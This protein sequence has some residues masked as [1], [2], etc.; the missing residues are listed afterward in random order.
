MQ[1]PPFAKF[2]VDR[3]SEDEVCNDVRHQN[4]QRRG[5]QVFG[6]QQYCQNALHKK[7][8]IICL[9]FMLFFWRKVGIECRMWIE[10]VVD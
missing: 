9:Q 7:L 4:S 6:R 2:V 3:P 8:S 5:L 1:E 10:R